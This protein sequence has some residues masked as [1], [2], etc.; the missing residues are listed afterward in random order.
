[1]KRLVKARE[2]RLKEMLSHFSDRGHLIAIIILA[3]PFLIPIPIPGLS[4]PFG[5]LIAITGAMLL[6]GRPPWV[7]KVLGERPLPQS[8]LAKLLRR[9]AGICRWIERLIR[10]RLGALTAGPARILGI[11]TIITCGLLLALPLPPGTNFLPALSIVLLAIG[12]LRGDGACV[13]A[14]LVV[15]ALNAV[16]FHSLFKIGHELIQ[17]FI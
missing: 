5:I 14:G 11:V 10:P 6:I 7:P 1:M 12:K 17:D 4:V 8:L 13:L 2:L 15:F 16:L 3:L 9:S